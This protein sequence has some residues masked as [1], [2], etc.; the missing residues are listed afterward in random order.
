MTIDRRHYYVQ[1]RQVL[2]L[3]PRPRLTTE[4]RFEDCDRCGERYIGELIEAHLR[5]EEKSGELL[6][7]CCE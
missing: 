2:G 7:V 6:R 5:T 1:C 3:F 4:E